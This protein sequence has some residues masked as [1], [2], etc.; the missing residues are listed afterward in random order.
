[1]SKSQQ[2]LLICSSLILIAGVSVAAWTLKKEMSSQLPSQEATAL[3]GYEAFVEKFGGDEKGLR[4]ELQYMLIHN[5]APLS[6]ADQSK[7]NKLTGE[8]TSAAS[9]LDIDHTRRFVE[10]STIDPLPIY[11]FVGDTKSGALRT[12]MGENATPEQVLKVQ[13]ALGKLSIEFETFR[14]TPDWKVEVEEK[15]GAQ[16]KLPF[17]DLLRSASEFMPANQHPSLRAEPKLPIFAGTD[18]E[19]LSQLDR[20]FNS[21]RGLAAF[22]KSKFPNIYQGDRI[23]PIP[24]LSHYRPQ[25]IAGLVEDKKLLLPEKNVRPEGVEAVEEVFSKLEQFFQAIDNCRTEIGLK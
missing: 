6:A 17:L 16:V 23:Q 8:L 21:P 9:L 13:K 10:V 1:V 19:L 20:F 3:P 11:H 22:P 14:E 24:P 2:L 15:D 25:I 18:A 12:L 5:S 4:G 7:I